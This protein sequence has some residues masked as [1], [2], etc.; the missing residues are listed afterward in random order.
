MALA[1]R[2]LICQDT[3][4]MKRLPAPLLLLLAA[5]LCVSCIEKKTQR[6][7]KKESPITAE[8][9]AIVEEDRAMRADSS[10]TPEELARADARHRE[11]VYRFLAQ[12]VVT[13]PEDLHRAALILYHADRQ[14]CRETHM[15]AYYLA[16]EA[17]EKGFEQ[18]RYLAALTLDRYL[19]SSGAPQ[20]YG[21]QFE[22]D[23]SGNHV[24]FP[25]DKTTTD[26]QRAAWHVPPLD[27]LRAG[28]S[29]PWTGP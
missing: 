20:E 23:S 16:Q 8:L 4:D 11:T 22:I 9:K 28:V 26:S 12:S 7:E 5:A 18:A 15:L 19:V 29:G 1:E 25:Y 3:V 2:F 17:V 13:E 10:V 21:T 27:S 6:L 14:D 24:L